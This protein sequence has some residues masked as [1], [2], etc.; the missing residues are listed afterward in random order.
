MQ[1][2][3]SFA[4]MV[5]AL[6]VGACLTLVGPGPAWTAPAA[7]PAADVSSQDWNRA[8]MSRG[9]D[10]EGLGAKADALA[11]YTLAIESHALAEDDQAR[12]HF[13]RGL[14]L[15]GMGRLNEALDDYSAALTLSPKFVAARNNRAGVYR[16]LSRWAQARQDYLDALV[17]GG[18]QSKDSYY[19]LGQIAEAEGSR[20]LAR[21][22]YQ[23][24][25][26]VD[27]QYT[28]A[29]DRLV[30]LP[31]DMPQLPQPIS[32]PAPRQD[33]RTASS[34]AEAPTGDSGDGRALPRQSI[35]GEGPHGGQVQLGA[36]RSEAAAIEG[37]KQAQRRAG[38]ALEGRS[39]RIQAVDLPGAGRFYR[40]RVAAD[41][42]GSGALCTVLTA[43]GQDCIP[44]RDR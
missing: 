12:A 2:F 36:W 7:L 6:L 41:L 18:P 30:A 16:R 31:G 38:E 35:L 26:M 15:D 28:L 19:G 32:P 43:K 33:I 39:P 22:F 27:P 25:L 20:T 34:G 44:A 9:H 42:T 21:D 8:L 13:D 11:D 23:R 14:L 10:S 17:P 4:A 3:G 24:A 29:R 40:L 5:R 1:R 37:W